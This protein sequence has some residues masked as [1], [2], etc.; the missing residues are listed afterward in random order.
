MTSEELYREKYFRK[1]RE[2][3]PGETINVMEFAK[4]AP[5]DFIQFGMQFI[6][7]GNHN[8]EFTDQYRCFRRMWSKIEDERFEV[9]TEN[10]QELKTAA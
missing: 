10:K 6:D 8:Y 1:F 3:Q 2:M 5:I 9:L 4:R 7:E